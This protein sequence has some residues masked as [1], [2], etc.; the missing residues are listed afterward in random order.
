MYN[1]ERKIKKL[2]LIYTSESNDSCEKFCFVEQIN[3]E[4]IQI[5]LKITC[6]N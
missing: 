5:E 2:K 4:E 3:F 1:D 6:N